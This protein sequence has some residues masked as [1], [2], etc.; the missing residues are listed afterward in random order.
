[1]FA[2]RQAPGRTILPIALSFVIL[3]TVACTQAAGPAGPGGPG[4]DASPMPSQPAAPLDCEQA[5]YP[6]SLQEVAP[7]VLARSHELGREGAA[8][9][10]DGRSPAEIAA[11]LQAKDGLAIVEHD[12]QGLRFRLDGGRF[13]WI[14]P[15]GELAAATT[16]A[17]RRLTGG[18]LPLS[19]GSLTPLAAPRPGPYPAARDTP[20]LESVV[21]QGEEHKS[22]IVIAP[23]TYLKG[24]LAAGDI[25]SVL[26]QTRGYDGRVTYV[27]NA[28]RDAGL[29][30]PAF[31]QLA[32]HDV[33]FVR[34]FGGHVCRYGGQDCFGFVAVSEMLGD[35]VRVP[36]DAGPIDM[37]ELPGGLAFFAVDADFFRYAYPGGLQHALI[38]FD[39]AGLKDQAL[40]SAVK[41]GTSAFYSWDGP[42]LSEET[43]GA[44]HDFMWDLARTGRTAAVV[45]EERALELRSDGGAFVG[46]NPAS[47][48]SVR[49]RDLLTIR[50]PISKDELISGEQMTVTGSLGDGQPDKVHFVVDIDGITEAESSRTFITVSVDGVEAPA[51]V[52]AEGGEIVDE[53]TWR[54]EGEVELPDLTE[55][56]DLDI[57]AVAILPEGGETQREVVVE[58]GQELGSVYEGEFTAISNTLWHG[59]T[60]KATAHVTFTRVPSDPGDTKIRFVPTSGTF[61]W[62]I[63][64]SSSKGCSHSAGPL[65]WP[66]DTDNGDALRFDLTRKAEGIIT[67]WGDGHVG[68]GPVVE[69]V[70]AC[71]DRTTSTG[72]RAEGSW[73]QAPRDQD[74]LFEGGTIVGSWR[75]DSTIG[76]TYSWS[77]KRVK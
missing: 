46:V 25:A 5:Q 9:L 69:L 30:M 54:V 36:P 74:F 43:N 44:I 35:Q 2:S 28:T 33:V 27:E 70:I 57:L 37:V 76:A 50:H 63:E 73:F 62:S 39:V 20:R 56:H 55:G 40:T 26:A 41:S 19:A 18:E 14:V 61:V 15:D 23:M 48:G 3:A 68:D 29:A 59:V 66:I 77:I 31:T 51:F 42:R 60:M 21:G 45:H 22:A 75:G 10:G 12:E 13:V 11:W 67:Y 71:P 47:A 49:I 1:M 24:S 53:F 38:V 17:G 65:T 4:G 72:T 52:P 34:S 7:D 16:A 32:G 58:V 6:C 8:K 64:G